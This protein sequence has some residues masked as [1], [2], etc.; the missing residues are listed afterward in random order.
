M[1][2]DNFG[3]R[4]KLWATINEPNAICR[5]GYGDNSMAPAIASDGIGEYQCAYNLIK[6]HASVRHLFTNEYKQKIDGK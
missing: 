5:L 6:A 2:F 3:N 4:V 1:A